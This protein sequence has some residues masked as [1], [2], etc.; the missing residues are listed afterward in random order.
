[1]DA[2]LE[3]IFFTAKKKVK[4][5]LKFA[6]QGGSWNIAYPLWAIF[7]KNLSIWWPS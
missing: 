6:L 2:S 5:E 7:Y 3:M 4:V 1:M